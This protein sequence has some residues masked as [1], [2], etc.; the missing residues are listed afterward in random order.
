MHSTVRLKMMSIWRDLIKMCVCI[1]L[2]IG[3]KGGGG[4]NIWEIHIYFKVGIKL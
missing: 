4:K 3:R 1:S 2:E